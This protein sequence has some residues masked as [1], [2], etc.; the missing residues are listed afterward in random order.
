MANETNITNRRADLKTAETGKCPSTRT[1]G[2]T[3]RRLVLGGCVLFWV[4]VIAVVIL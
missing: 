1:S 4:A 2:L 3:L